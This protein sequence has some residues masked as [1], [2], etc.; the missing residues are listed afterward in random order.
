[1]SSDAPAVIKEE[2]VNRQIVGVGANVRDPILIDP[3]QPIQY[4]APSCEVVF[5]QQQP[6]STQYQVKSYLSHAIFREFVQ[7]ISDVFG[8]NNIQ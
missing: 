5:S 7:M 1:M 4:E 2:P 3:N 8:S 6:P